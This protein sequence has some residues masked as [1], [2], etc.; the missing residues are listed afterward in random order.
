MKLS[1]YIYVLRFN[2]TSSII[3]NGITKKFVVIPQSRVVPYLKL[4]KKCASDS[5]D[6]PSQD[7]TFARKLKDAG[8]LVENGL[9]ER[10]II[11]NDELSYINDNCY[12]T[13]L[14]PTYDCNYSCWYCT[15]KHRHTKLEALDIK[16]I[17]R[18][19][20]SYILKNQIAAYS[21]CWFGGE[22]L[23]QKQN[24]LKITSF[25]YWWCKRH[26]VKF[27]GQMT[28]NGALF[29]ESA[30]ASL[31]DCHVNSYQITLDG[32]RAAHN[33]VKREQGG[34]SSFD[35]VL[36]NVRRVLEINVDAT[37]TLRFNYSKKTLADHGIVGEICQVIPRSLRDRIVVDLE[38]IWQT[39]GVEDIAASDLYPVLDLFSREGFRLSVGGFFNLCYTE[40]KHF[41]TIYYNGKVDF[42]DNYSE[43]AARGYIDENGDTKW[44][45][46]PIFKK[47]ANKQTAVCRNCLYYPVCT[48]ECPAKRDSRLTSGSPFTCPKGQKARIEYG[49]LD[50]CC[51]SILNSRN[52][53]EIN[54]DRK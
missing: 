12:Q 24:V 32:A 27:M 19:I 44:K 17:K 25:L 20:C 18:H 2:G 41:E 46:V 38:R 33:R 36:H 26:G 45:V 5:F 16:K 3:F 37:V 14:I 9:D 22:P 10:E 31:R 50:Y 51:R 40:K 53:V 11:K 8:F 15:Q 54:E 6:E 47:E 28:T 39:Q 42:C 4:L 43:D 21:L 29:D 13:M 30:I 7:S 48:G 1:D 52:K 23:V 34:K 49:I 35:I